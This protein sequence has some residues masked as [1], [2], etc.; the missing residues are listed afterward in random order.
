MR[1][2]DEGKDHA[3]EWLSQE[4]RKPKSGITARTS[5]PA[6]ETLYSFELENAGIR[7]G[8]PL[9]TWDDH[10][11]DTEAE[12]SLARLMDRLLADLSPQQ[13][14]AIELVVVAGMSYGSAASEM[15]V[16]KATVHS[17]CQDGLARLR[18]SLAQN[19]WAAAIVSP[20][21]ENSEIGSNGTHGQSA[22][23]PPLS[24]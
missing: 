15:G 10:D 5:R 4:T 14:R 1:Y 2:Y 21:L 12:T 18:K 13:K 9:S 23:L 6:K 11:V 24:S 7:T 8:I 19:P 3:A 20:W 16:A 17:H 22:K